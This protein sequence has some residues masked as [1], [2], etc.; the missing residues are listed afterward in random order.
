MID[1]GKRL[2]SKTVEIKT[3][4]IEIYKDLDRS[5]G[6][7]PLRPAQ[8]KIL[9]KWYEEVRTNKDV[10]IKL[11]TGEGKT[12]IGLLILFS[13][14]NLNQGPCLYVCPNNYLV[15]Q[16]AKEAEK[17]GIPHCTMTTTEIPDDFISGK[18]VLI[19]T[20]QKLFNG[21]TVFKLDNQSLPVGCVVLDDAHACIDSIKSA[22][23]IR[24][25]REKELLYNKLLDIFENDLIEQGEGSYIDIRHGNSIEDV[26]SV[27]YWAWIDKK[28]DLTELL[29]EYSTHDELKFVWPLIRN[30]LE[31]CQM[32]ITNKG[33]EISPYKISIE[34]F[35][36]FDRASQRIMMSATTQDDSFFIK[37]FNFDVS[38]I[39]HP[40]TDDSQK[41]SGE[42]MILIPS[43]IDDNLIRDEIISSLINKKLTDFGIVALVPGF[44]Y[45]DDYRFEGVRISTPDNI[46]VNVNSLKM[47]QFDYPVVIANRYDGIDLPDAACRILILDSLPFSSNLADRYEEQCRINS[48]I[49][50]IKITQKIEQGLGRSVRGEKDYSVIIIIGNDLVRFVKSSATNKFFSDQTK[51]QISLGIEIADMAMQEISDGILPKDVLKSLIN[52]CLKRDEGWKQFYK[53]EMDNIIPTDNRLFVYRILET[54]RKAEN[55]HLQGNNEKACEVIQ[56]LID[57]EHFDD[58]EKGWYLQTKARYM[59]ADSKIDA[60]KIQ[61]TAFRLNNQLLKPA[62]G[63]VYKKIGYIN[64]NRNKRIRT[65]ISQFK[66]YEDFSL[67]INDTLAN[68]SF[69]ISAEKF[70]KALCEIGS[71]LGFISQ[72]PDKEIRKGPDN[73]WCGI[74]N[75]YFLFECK[76]EVDGDRADIHKHEVGQMNNHCGWFENEYKEKPNVKYVMIIPTLFVA[77]DANFTHDVEIMRKGKLKSLKMN[78]ANFVKEFKHYNLQELSDDVIQNAIAIHQLD[79]KNLL[80]DYSEKY[81]K[82]EKK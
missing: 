81:K 17:F 3:N 11:H 64:E 21:K 2:Q 27:P 50:N 78:I 70:E 31:E 54:E 6:T 60:T 66:N 71:L 68:L 51:K 52:Q 16:V 12:L 30:S 4:P 9:E 69:G 37:G 49:I 14:L 67:A 61:L 8:V 26:M 32:F 82:R 13:K 59:Y 48:D 10:V 53:T 43:I 57:Q 75:Q 36:S 73:L 28:S 80:T 23:T 29:S 18:K 20:I 39:E 56:N 47:R 24:V 63:I 15:T 25:P 79:I 42:K 77:H 46:E 38:A 19:I 34:R 40:L 44:R 22:F 41:W 55:L 5:A 65:Y 35:G 7:G 45:F 33:I 1:F 58:S 76:T 62:Q 74:D 72:R